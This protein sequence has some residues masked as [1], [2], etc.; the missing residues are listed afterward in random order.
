MYSYSCE[1]VHVTCGVRGKGHDSITTDSAR[2]QG[3]RKFWK[4]SEVCLLFVMV[5]VAM[6]QTGVQV[7]FE[8]SD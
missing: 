1:A 4:P 5:M 3:W 6:A 2:R 8:L 7:S